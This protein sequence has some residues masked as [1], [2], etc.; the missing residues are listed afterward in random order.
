MSYQEQISQ[1]LK[2]A[3]EERVLSSLVE[4]SDELGG[5]SVDAI[6]LLHELA[7][8]FAAGDY[9]AGLM[10]EYAALI[11][12]PERAADMSNALSETVAKVGLEPGYL[13]PDDLLDEALVQA[14]RA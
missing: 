12:D 10:S 8:Q 4:P 5:R 14:G 13:H 2:Q 7:D 6:L 1:A 9:D 3:A 11:E